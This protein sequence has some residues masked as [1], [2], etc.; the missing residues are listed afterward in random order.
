MSRQER[1]SWVSLVV[2][3]I[4]SWLYFS[5]VWAMPVDG[6][7]WL[8]AP[9]V[10]GLIG[11]AI[12]LGIASEIAFRMVLATGGQPVDDDCRQDERDQ[13]IGLKASRNGY[14]VLSTASTLAGMAVYASRI[15]YYRRGS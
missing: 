4:I 8:H 1:V 6:R 3:V 14:R 12:V 7:L 2:S 9:F 11:L 13:Q 15:V 10:A 5:R